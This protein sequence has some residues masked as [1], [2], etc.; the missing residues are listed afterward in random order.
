MIKARRK[1][2]SALT[3]LFVLM[4]VSLLIP[5]GR[6][7]ASGR[8]SSGDA[9]DEVIKA[10]EV[11]FMELHLSAPYVS[12][13]PFGPELR[14]CGI[15]TDPRPSFL[16][17]PRE[18][19]ELELPLGSRLVS[20]SLVDQVVSHTDI[21]VKPGHNPP[22]T[23]HGDHAGFIP[24]DEVQAPGSFMDHRIRTGI[25]HE[26]LETKAYLS[27]HISPVISS[28]EGFE[29]L[30]SGS[31]RVEY[32]PPQ[33]SRNGTPTAG[34]YDVLVLC[35]DELTEDA[36]GYADYRNATGLDTKVV[37]LS[38]IEDDLYWEIAEN[39]TQEEIKRFIYLARLEWGIDFVVLAGDA[40]YIPARH[41]LVLDGFDDD[42]DQ[43]TDGAFVPSDLYYSDIFEEGT[44]TFSNWNAHDSG[45][46]RYLWGEYSGGMNDDPDL[47]PDV[48][49]GR[50]PAS[51]P[52]EY[53]SMVQKI[54]G[55]ELNARGSDWFNNVTLCGTDTFTEYTGAEG[56][57]TCEYI[58]SSF[59]HTGYNI[60]T[61]YETDG[62]IDNISRTIDRGTGFV[63]MSDHGEYNGWGY[64]AGALSS[65]YSSLDANRQENGYM[66][67]IVVMDACLTHGFD[68][69]NASDPIK[70][71]DPIYNQYYYPPG[72]GLRERD[73]LG[74]YLHKNPDGG[75][76]ASFG[77]TR[78][79][80]GSAGV[81]YPQVTSGY[82]NVRINKAYYDGLRTAGQLLAR[83]QSDYVR[84]I[85]I[86]GV[87]DYK[88]VTE[89]V[90]LGDP[91]LMVGGVI[92]NR[93]DLEFSADNVTV[94]PGQEIRVNFTIRNAGIIDA[95]LELNVTVEGNNHHVW[96]VN[97]SLERALLPPG[98][99]LK[100]YVD[101]YAPPLVKAAEE[102]SVVLRASSLLL[103]GSERATLHTYAL[104]TH[105]VSMKPDPVIA[106]TSQ[107]SD[108]EGFIEFLNLGNGDETFNISFPDLPEGWKVRMNEF[109]VDV[110]AFGESRFPFKFTLPN[111]TLSGAYNITIE[112]SSNTT[113]AGSSTF[114]QVI[115][116]EDRTFT[117]MSAEPDIRILPGE[118]SSVEIG[119][120][121]SANTD[122][123]ID[124]DWSGSR[125]EG[126]V[127]GFTR[128][129]IEMAPFNEE[130]TRM[131]V[132]PPNGT[133][134]GLYTVRLSATARTILR[135][136]SFD[137]IV[138][139][140]YGFRAECSNPA[141]GIYPGETASF[142]INVTN[143]GNIF[144]YYN[145]TFTDHG[146]G[147]WTTS[148][149]P[150]TF[151]VQKGSFRIFKVEIM[152]DKPLNGTYRFMLEIDPFST[153]GKQYIDLEVI[154]KS[155][156]GYNLDGG[157]STDRGAP[158]SSLRA[159][160]TLKNLANVND[161]YGINVKVPDGWSADIQ[162]WDRTLEPA[163][164][165]V[166][167][168]NVSIPEEA[169]AGEFTVQITVRSLG[170]SENRTF[171]ASVFVTEVYD[172]RLFFLIEGDVMELKPG[173]TRTI[174]V[175]I[176]NHGNTE[177]NV[178]IAI[179]SSEVIK[180][181]IKLSSAE[182]TRVGP[183]EGPSFDIIITVPKNVTEG[184]Y[185]LSILVGSMGQIDSMR[186]NITLRVDSSDRITL[187]D[188]INI[189]PVVVAAAAGLGIVIL[190]AFILIRVYRK[191]SGVAIE[192]AG[193]EW[194]EDE[195]DGDERSGW[196]DDWE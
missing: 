19:L 67:P 172:L 63:I 73:S 23:P 127:L 100:G 5:V 170:S 114:L 31:V 109:M 174:K 54:K 62:T 91:S 44:T 165:H 196:D 184:D 66:L 58:N 180:G 16:R 160:Y 187:L 159:M 155:S 156:Y 166:L 122:L 61:H 189:I 143:L 27:V 115:V 52:E 37:N 88:T 15:E 28:G 132:H 10:G 133:D 119:L 193:M 75:G 152:A 194:E 147:N 150:G 126:W 97:L 12:D 105:G 128:D 168:F 6:I 188:Q 38:A 47:L 4:T 138:G 13:G 112:A 136:T 141:V 25:D 96:T 86:S 76:I 120:V 113:E 29:I 129:R 103:I 56:E 121:S 146:N 154:V 149:T 92:G 161:T 140:V 98:G 21:P 104:R 145:A 191:S 164:E 94:P 85:G 158:G 46:F 77:C 53:R 163:E 80:Y 176:E 173:T 26:T 41:I 142:Q 123:T 32:Q 84:N 181:W 190:V 185:R 74:E 42:G 81:T 177:D 24:D 183:G 153:T 59:Y 8:L 60:T 22:A 171:T 108:V 64:V 179:S 14:I 124:L 111:M 68:N 106:H 107:G 139:S 83:A 20:V 9:D 65:K 151:S 99:S 36:V 33:I 30:L 55:Y 50:I 39:D 110:D 125:L 175:R 192:D 2:S 182:I 70:G 1:E 45:S 49:V 102:R 167:G 17:L 79:G 71:V 148:I 72:R 48:Y 34:L 186:K 135:E 116:D 89:Y 144:D 95:D 35:P 82:M 178:Q 195:D 11:E 157:F 51:S 69:E 40:N 57:I 3:V 131:W 87:T 93:V 118:N 90:L 137:V 117:I 7:H 43:N 18:N 130:N 169:L 134:P 78:V 162:D 101:L